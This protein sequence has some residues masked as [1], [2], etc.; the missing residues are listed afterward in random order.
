MTQTKRNW[1]SLIL[2]GDYEYVS[3]QE[4][5]ARAAL[6]GKL[7]ALIQDGMYGTDTTWRRR[8]K[9]LLAEASNE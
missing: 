3:L 7:V 6:V 4:A 2:L 8:A 1:T 5:E 9:A